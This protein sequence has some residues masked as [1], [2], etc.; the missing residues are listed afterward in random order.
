MQTKN[1]NAGTVIVTARFSAQALGPLANAGANAI[2]VSARVQSGSNSNLTLQLE[3]LV[4][5][6]ADIIIS[7]TGD[8]SFGIV[9]IEGSFDG[10][11][12]VPLGTFNANT[13][14]GTQ[15]ILQHITLTSP[16]GG[17]E[18]IRFLR[19]QG[20]V[21]VDGVSYT[22]VCA[23]PAVI[24]ASKTVDVYD[25]TGSGTAYALPGN[26]MVYKITATNTGGSAVDAD[27]IV[28]ID[29]LPPEIKFFNGDVDGGGPALDPIHFTQS[30]GAGLDF[31]YTRDVRFG[32][33]PTKPTDFSN[34]TTVAPDS[35]YRPDFQFICINPKG[36]LIS[37]NVSPSFSVAFRVGIK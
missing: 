10:N 28:L 12:F 4:P 7:I 18:F 21:W 9:N 29:D 23:L 1:G 20:R 36:A 26:D 37:G 27:S 35:T 33:G 22:D 16:A 5:E 11:T 34:C 15:D 30:A 17:M 25:P 6:N 8:N 2:G 24:T 13:S 3:D 32:L 31:V 14:G 19:T